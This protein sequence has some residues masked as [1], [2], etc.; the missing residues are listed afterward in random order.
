MTPT[1]LFF[2]ERVEH[3]FDL[4][5]TMDRLCRL[6]RIPYRIVGGLAVYLYVEAKEP[7]AGRLTRDVDVLILREDLPRL[8][9]AAERVG[10]QH[11]HAADVD[12]LV[13]AEEPSAR[14]AIHL[15]FSGE[16][17]RRDYSE[18]APEMGV[19]I[20]LGELHVVSLESLIRMKLTSFRAKDEAHLKDLDDAGLISPEIESRLS[21]VLKE[22][23]RAMRERE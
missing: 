14:R 20:S 10:F 11:R 16:K 9:A 3:L 15:V 17:V 5:Q 22:R 19:P 1:N 6:A 21:T 23:L 13:S 8:V 2:E 7:A 12:M 4:A 18:P